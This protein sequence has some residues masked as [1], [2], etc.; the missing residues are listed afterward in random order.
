MKSLTEFELFVIFANTFL[1]FDRN[2]KACN[3]VQDQSF[4]AELFKK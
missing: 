2:M 1:Y 3:K 4:N